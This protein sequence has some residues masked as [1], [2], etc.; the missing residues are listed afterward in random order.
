MATF[1]E[2]QRKRKEALREVRRRQRAT[3]SSIE[4]MERRIFRLLDRKTLLNVNDAIELYDKYYKEFISNVRLLERGLI[5][6]FNLINS[7]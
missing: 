5:A 1:A 2:V 4:R 6:F 7:D 3:D